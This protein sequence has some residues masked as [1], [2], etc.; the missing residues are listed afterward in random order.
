MLKHLTTAGVLAGAAILAATAAQA[1]TI[2]Y[3][4]FQPAALDQP[5]HAAALAFK[6]HVEAATGGSV[7]VEIFPASQLGG[8]SE[9]ME[10]LQLGTIQLG[11]VHDGPIGSTFAPFQVFQI[12]YV[13]PSQ[14]VAWE[15]LDGDYG[16]SVAEAMREQTGIRLMAYADNG[17]RHFT[18]NERSIT[19]PADME[20]LKIRV[21]PSPVFQRLVESLG[22]S[23]TVIAW[24]E[25]P[26]ALAQGVVDG[27]ENGVTNILAADLYENQQFVSLD[28]H[29]YS[30]HAYMMND[31]FFQGLE[32][33]E[34]QAVTEGIEI[35]KWIHR[36]MTAAQDANAQTILSEVGMEV[37]PL[38][39]DQVA[40]FRAKAQSPVAE[41]VAGEVGQA[42]VDGL[43]AA[44]ESGR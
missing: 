4:H 9:V 11:V 7:T 42:W 35:A 39:P 21:Q 30:L 32:E 16:D 27:Q 6:S 2:R 33:S 44:V 20:G 5:K 12:P 10:G 19:S 23:P 31:A 36:G 26:S 34:Q 13:F 38:S 43:F 37:T 41:W 8:G 24:P 17:I 22:A 29:V 14:T 40:A 15:V 25:L 18:N 28:G 1:N 3:A